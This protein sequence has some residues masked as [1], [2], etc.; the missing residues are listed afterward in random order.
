MV[1][2][3]ATDRARRITGVVS[4]FREATTSFVA[5]CGSGCLALSTVFSPVSTFAGVASFSFGLSAKAAGVSGAPI[6]SL[7]LV[8]FEAG[9]TCAIF[10]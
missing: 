8:G 5:T 3:L 9:V 10:C 1:A 7:V 2:A 4:S 6:C